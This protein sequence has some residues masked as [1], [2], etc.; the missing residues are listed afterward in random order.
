MLRQVKAGQLPLSH[1][2]F[3][4]ML[5][6]ARVRERFHEPVVQ[7]L[8]ATSR[9][10][11]ELRANGRQPPPRCCAA[12]SGDAL[13]L[14]SGLSAAAGLLGGAVLAESVVGSMVL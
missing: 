1:F 5:S 12:A 2:S 3:A 9:E 7:H 8:A 10:A 6:L 4:L 11:Y 14:P 13:A